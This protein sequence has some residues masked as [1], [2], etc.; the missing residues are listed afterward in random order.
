MD[1]AA[2]VASQPR[3]LLGEDEPQDLSMKADDAG[4]SSG[5]GAG[6]SS[7]AGA[8]GSGA[9]ASSSSSQ[10]IFGLVQID[11]SGSSSSRPQ[12]SLGTSL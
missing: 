7:D 9:G 12:A 11:D 3:P 6:A 2:T 8:G 1:A 10:D 4:G 5:A